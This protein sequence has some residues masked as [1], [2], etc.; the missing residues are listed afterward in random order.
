ME[1]DSPTFTAN[2]VYPTISLSDEELTKIYNNA[3]NIGEGK[4]PPITTERIFKAMR[5]CLNIGLRSNI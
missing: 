2:I 4:S 5:A 1:T 3:N